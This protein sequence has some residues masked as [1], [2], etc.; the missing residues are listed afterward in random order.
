[1]PSSAARSA[2]RLFRALLAA[3]VSLAAPACSPADFAALAYPE[4]G[5]NARAALL[6]IEAE[7]G[8]LGVLAVAWPATEALTREVRGRSAVLH[9]AAFAESLEEL[10]LAPGPVES[11]RAG[12][13]LPPFLSAFVA[14]VEPGE[15]ATWEVRTKLE[16]PLS[17]VRAPSRSTCPTDYAV[18]HQTLEHNRMIVT[19]RSLG[20]D[21]VL[22]LAEQA[23]D[24]SDPRGVARLDSRG[25]SYIH[26]DQ[27]I[28]P[29]P[30]CG[31]RPGS[32]FT[33]WVAADGEI[34]ASALACGARSYGVYHGYLGVPL[35]PTQPPPDPFIDLTALAGVG[36]GAAAVVFGV[37]FDRALWR[38]RTGAWEVL[39]T[40]PDQVHDLAAL[41]P[42][43][44]VGV[45]GPH[46]EGRTLFHYRQGQVTTSAAG[47][48]IHAFTDT[49]A[50]PVAI[51][52]DLLGTNA[53]VHHFDGTEWAAMPGYP[54]T[55]QVRAVSAFRDGFA[56]SGDFGSIV[57]HT[58]G[59]FCPSVDG[60]LGLN[61]NEM[62]PLGDSLVLVGE[63]A[64]D[65]PSPV[66]IAT[67]R[68]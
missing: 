56:Y 44:V 11:G 30:D 65:T 26:P 21:A 22:L 5:S 12:D 43:E 58:G 49:P 13:E 68:P 29:T 51:E 46:H 18:D 25:I 31:S 35:V 24:R 8:A 53:V 4:V 19:A 23:F 15:P 34:W 10:G 27:V 60:K 45:L 38:Y 28:A 20:G 16:A 2:P 66:A 17:E 1:M 64:N 67:P 61:V 57:A 52:F 48:T 9:L 59:T 39:A 47:N 6:S 7:D 40:L 54:R 14:T 33:V 55:Q 37:T 36:T 63:L 32:L 62:A 41:G 42:E 50:G 3:A